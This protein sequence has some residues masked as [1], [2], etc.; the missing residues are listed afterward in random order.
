M[1][2]SAR[3]KLDLFYQ[4]LHNSISGLACTSQGNSDGQLCHRYDPRKGAKCRRGS[5]AIERCDPKKDLCSAFSRYRTIKSSSP[6]PLIDSPFIEHGL[7]NSDLTLRRLI[8]KGA[9][10]LICMSKG[11][12]LTAGLHLRTLYGFL[13]F[14]PSGSKG[15]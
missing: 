10:V 1:L 7:Q 5:P 13:G 15:V 9:W 8:A 14:F 12:R 6:F 11:E 4:L 2:F 3:I